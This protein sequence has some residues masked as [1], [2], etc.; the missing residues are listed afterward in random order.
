M[1]DRN[2]STRTAQ[3]EESALSVRHLQGLATERAR[4]ALAA[5]DVSAVYRLLTESGVSQRQI[6]D[7]TGQSQ[8]EVS[9]ILKGRQVMAYDVL[10]RIAEG[11]GVQRAWMGLAYDEVAEPA[12]PAVGE[13]VVDEDMRR[14]A[15]LAAASIALLGAPVLGEV[16]ELPTPP[17]TPTPL[18]SRL[19]ASDVAAVKELTAQLRTVTRTYGG[20][21]DV[22][23]AVANRSRPLMSVPASKPIK[24]ELGSA[25]ADL[26]T[27]AGWCCV[28]SRL[29][30][31]ARAC[32][33][34]A[35][36]LAAGV[37]DG[38]QLASALRHA[39][40]QMRDAGAYND[41][42]KACQLGLI[43][44]GEAPDSPGAA[45]AAAW[46]NV[47]SARV[48]AAM[49]HSDAAERSLKTA[50][51]WRPATAYDVADME[52][53][54]SYVYLRLG[55]LDT[56]ERFAASSVRK[57]AAEGTSRR[58]GV[59]SDI[60]LATIHTRTGQSDA[61]ALAERAIAGVAP[62]R[63]LRTRRVKLA[64]LVDALDARAD[65]TSRDLAYRARQLAS[66]A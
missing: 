18:P 6:A 15:L 4:R 60:S 44:L 19:G 48:L 43:K 21:A 28:D 62:L 35:M 36:D 34:T 20:G 22:V 65:S 39:G 56:A 55:R 49:G 33:A 52:C 25:L 1:P 11:L 13:E 45:E 16:L 59:L 30:D 5:R 64:P 12:G 47:E 66:T 9:E 63:S 26:H 8:S 14:R 37:G 3:T 27:L 38:V 61:S 2:F 29:H 42:L 53:V 41:G 31:Q 7:L 54:T 40:I 51:E 10:V 57:W 17:N 32:F 23:T 58:E 46:L 50:R 24:A